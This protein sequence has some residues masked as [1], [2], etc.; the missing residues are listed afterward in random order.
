[1][2]VL[3]NTA[4]N[5]SSGRLSV[6]VLSVFPIVTAFL[7]AAAVPARAD[8]RPDEAR[9]VY[10]AGLEAEIRA[11]DGCVGAEQAVVSLGERWERAIAEA[12]FDPAAAAPQRLAERLATP[13]R[14]AFLARDK[15][16]VVREL[17][18]ELLVQLQHASAEPLFARMLEVRTCPATWIALA[19][20]GLARLHSERGRVA[21]EEALVAAVPAGTAPHDAA[22]SLCSAAARVSGSAGASDGE[23]A[24][25]TEE[26]AE[27]ARRLFLF[28]PQIA[29]QSCMPLV[30]RLP[31]VRALAERVLD[32]A[33]WPIPVA[34]AGAD[35]REPRMLGPYA[36]GAALILLGQVRA[37]G[38]YERLAAALE[39]RSWEAQ[40]TRDGAI[41]GLAALGGSRARVRLRA[42]L[43]DADLRTPRVAHALLRLG[44]TLAAAPLREVALDSDAIVEMR[45]SAA[46]AYT[47]LAPARPRLAREWERD[48]GRAP[49]LGSPFES[50]D[51]RM[52]EM[53]ARLVVTERCAMRPECWV[54]SIASGDPQEAARAFFQLSRSTLAE[55]AEAAP[56]LADAAARTLAETPPNERHDLVSGAV[57]LLARLEQEVAR[58][59][60]PVVRR[61]RV[62]WEGRTNPMGLPFDIPLA[63]GQLE[64]RLSP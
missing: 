57:A 60:L 33:D 37:D 4:G 3:C 1:M 45:I 5:L 28:A 61:A 27:A 42:A 23:V 41:Q 62:A 50:L 40:P 55:D 38:A 7:L 2:G 54:E 14:R 43:R 10:E 63:L 19:A 18:L 39:D 56:L 46:N 47:L 6:P 26:V 8:V 64:R 13:L 29:V 58:P 24:S 15:P 9:A 51:A 25:S 59:Y 52:S 48:L 31:D 11:L 30:A 49:P 12:A 16:R 22:W 44:D 20:D 36:R 17:A 35:P 53:T 21:I 32:G 34:G